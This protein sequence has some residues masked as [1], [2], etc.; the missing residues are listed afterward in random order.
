MRR[1]EAHD[2]LMAAYREG[3]FLE[4]D[5]LAETRGHLLFRALARKSVRTALRIADAFAG[6]TLFIPQ[7]VEEDVRLVDGV[8]KADAQALIDLLPNGVLCV[9]RLRGLRQR[10]SIEAAR[11]RQQHRDLE[12]AGV[13]TLKG[14]CVWTGK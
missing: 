11:R 2:G 14:E 7:G 9:P 13:T 5:L 10:A 4:Q 12:A 3:L 1:Q 6:E 8:S